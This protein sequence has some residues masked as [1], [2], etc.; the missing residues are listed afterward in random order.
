[1]NLAITLVAAMLLGAGF[2]LQQYAAEQAPKAHFLRLALIA[3]LLRRRRWLLGIAVMVAGQLASAWSVSH[4]SLSLAE[5]LLSTNLLFALAL[6]VPLSGQRLRLTELFGA[7]ILAGGVSALSVARTV[8]SP[9]A[10]FRTPAGWL[11]AAVIAAIAALFVQ[12]GLRR[13]GTVRAT[14]TGTAAGLVFGICDALTRLTV[15]IMES[16]PFVHLLTIWPGYSLIAANLVGL[17]LMQSAFNS[18]PLHASLPGIS[19]AEPLAGIV[20]G[21]VV[22]GDAIRISPPMLALQAAGLAALVSGVVL[23]ARAPALSQLKPRPGVIAATSRHPISTIRT[24][25]VSAMHPEESDAPDAEQQEERDVP[26][27][28]EPPVTTTTSDRRPT[29]V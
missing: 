19:A 18:A 4:I 7:L 13:S 17:W 15:H 26:E 2:V 1:M 9:S 22:F 10:T 8:H 20:L 23:V 14:L 27:V 12:A 25:A 5:P 29:G 28:T 11:G 24:A 6:A 3:D 21:V 16:H